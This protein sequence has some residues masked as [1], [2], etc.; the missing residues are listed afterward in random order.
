VAGA[1][2]SATPS[3]TA[4]SQTGDAVLDG[5]LSLLPFKVPLNRQINS[6]QDFDVN[7]LTLSFTCGANGP[8]WKMVNHSSKSFGFGWFDTSLG[9]GIEQIGPGRTMEI[10][11]HALAV[12]A[13]PW[14]GETKE[15][16]VT[17]PTVG[18]SNCAGTP[19]AVTP[20]ALPV[21]VPAAAGGAGAVPVVQPHFTG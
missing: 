6:I 21:A 13:A 11:S 3:P 16:L 8:D 9:G 18:V 19:A 12:I 15:L 17:V 5:F 10:K 20:V 2:K 7:P 1:G 4:N 14:D